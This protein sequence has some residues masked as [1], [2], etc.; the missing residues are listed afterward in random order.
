MMDQSLS[1]M[2]SSISNSM[3]MSILSFNQNSDD[4][5]CH[6]MNQFLNRAKLESSKGKCKPVPSSFLFMYSQPLIS[7]KG[8]E[9][10]E[11]IDYFEEEQI[12]QKTLKEGKCK[13]DYIYAPATVEK[14]HYWIKQGLEILHFSGHGV[15]DAQKKGNYLLF[16]NER[17]E[18]VNVTVAGLTELLQEGVNSLKLVFVASCHSESAGKVFAEA[19]A[20]HV[21]CIRDE[22]QILDEACQ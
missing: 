8:R 21:I 4:P 17:G 5:L 14:L 11:Q 2:G 1:L 18:S 6:L 15:Y 10:E 9:I 16:E 20:S 13:V 3:T 19:G 12:I 7:S 22:Y